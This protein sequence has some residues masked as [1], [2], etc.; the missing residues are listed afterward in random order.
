MSSV[1]ALAA[2]HAIFY[3]IQRSPGV[4]KLRMWEPHPH[5]VGGVSLPYLYAVNYTFQK[6]VDAEA[7]LREY[8]LVNGAFD[9]PD[10]NFPTEGR[11][12]ILPYPTWSGL[13]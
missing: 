9:V 7:F 3:R 1:H 12:E 6:V 8:L 13:E 10:R 2:D 5:S 4:V 11:I